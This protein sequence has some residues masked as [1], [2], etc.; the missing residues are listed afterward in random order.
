MPDSR[1]TL[2]D[3]GALDNVAETARKPELPEDEHAIGLTAVAVSGALV[4]APWRRRGVAQ[5][6]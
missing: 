5:D 3:V 4:G 6:P 1:A 2:A